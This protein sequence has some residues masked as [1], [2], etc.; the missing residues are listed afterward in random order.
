MASTPTLSQHHVLF[1]S[2][3][4]VN[5]CQSSSVSR[6]SFCLNRSWARRRGRPAAEQ[7]RHL[8]PVRRSWPR[9]LAPSARM[10]ST[11]TPRAE[12]TRPLPLCLASLA[13][14]APAASSPSR[15]HSSELVCAPRCV[16]VHQIPPTAS[17]WAALHFRPSSSPRNPPVSRHFLLS[18][19]RV[20]GTIFSGELNAEPCEVACLLWFGPTG[21]VGP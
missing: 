1:R 19:N 21:R 11:A 8:V 4:G 15:A 14:R 20:A 9:L 2:G 7:R 17:P 6:L 13:R 12:W 5:R 16:S 18:P 3:L 10:T